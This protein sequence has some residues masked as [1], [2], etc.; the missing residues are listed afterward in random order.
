MTL[1]GGN[2]RFY[3]F[4]G[5]IATAARKTEHKEKKQNR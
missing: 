1:A 2:K 3:N 4:F 5:R